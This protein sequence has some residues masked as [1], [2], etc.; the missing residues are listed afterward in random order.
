MRLNIRLAN[1]GLRRVLLHFRF[2]DLPAAFTGGVTR[3]CILLHLRLL[4]MKPFGD[5]K[6]VVQ[7]IIA[8][9]NVPF[10]AHRNRADQHIDWAGLTPVAS[11]FV[12]QTC[13]VLVIGRVPHSFHRL[14]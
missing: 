3:L 11:A 8:G 10:S 4:V 14:E 2:S 12:I 1:V 5:C 7:G 9:E 6:T 13:G